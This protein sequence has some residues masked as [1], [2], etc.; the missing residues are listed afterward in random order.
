MSETVVLAEVRDASPDDLMLMG[1]LETQ[2]LAFGEVPGVDLGD[3]LPLKLPVWLQEALAPES[4]TVESVVGHEILYCWP[5]RLGGWARG[6]V[7]AVNADQ[8]KKIGKEVCNF[9][10]HYPVDDDTSEHLL[11]TDEYATNGKAVGGSW[12]LL[13]KEE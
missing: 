2:L 9:L 4:Q 13:G 12:V 6:T 1:P 8:T 3:L 7:S 11:K 10:V 5:A